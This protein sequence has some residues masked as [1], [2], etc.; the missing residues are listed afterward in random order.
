MRKKLLYTKNTYII[1]LLLNIVT[2]G[3][4]ALVVSG[5]KF[6]YACVKEVCRLW[7]QPRFTPFIHW[8]LLLKRCDKEGGQTTPSWN[9]AAVL[10][11]GQLHSYADA[12]CD[13]GAL[14]CMS[15][16]HDFCSQ[17][18]ALSSFFFSVFAYSSNYIM[19]PCYMNSTI[20]APFR[21]QKTVAIS[22]LAGRR[23]LF[24][25]FRLVWWMC[26]HPLLWL[27]FDFNIHKRNPGFIAC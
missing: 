4:E 16:F 18:P 21:S 6:L 14:Q 15:E 17:W 1:Q 26:M 27:L 22:F 9:A 7:A 2:A 20:S 19:V 13:G 25:L 11:C 23:H 8:L 5:N 12:H 10:E 24:K 3:I